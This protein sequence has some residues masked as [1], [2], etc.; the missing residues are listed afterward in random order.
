MLC[1]SCLIGQL[2]YVSRGRYADVDGA[3]RIVRIVNIF[4]TDLDDLRT[5]V[6][7]LKFRGSRMI[8]DS[9]KYI[10]VNLRIL[11]RLIGLDNVFVILNTRVRLLRGMKCR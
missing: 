6:H 7:A 3:E 2:L 5:A 11:I 8:D 10:R 4:K 9:F 1:R